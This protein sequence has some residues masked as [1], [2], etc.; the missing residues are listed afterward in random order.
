MPET[1][2]GF[3]PD[4]GATWLLAHS[5]AELGTY[6]GLTGEQIGASD[7]IRAGLADLYVPTSVLPHI[8]DAL[9]ALPAGA[10]ADNSRIRKILDPFAL[11]I[12]PT[13]IQQNRHEIDRIFAADKIE[14]ILAALAQSGTEFARKTRATLLAK[15]PTS[16]KLTVRLIRLA[17]ASTSLEQCLNREFAAGRL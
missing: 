16:L 5:P 3:F 7:A 17:A 12:E 14:T 9:E 6:L 2:I 4:V 8:K 15:S 1:G 13:P 11:P 10:E